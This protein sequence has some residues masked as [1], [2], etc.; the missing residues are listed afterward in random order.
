[1]KSD[2]TGVLH[3]QSA[4]QLYLLNKILQYKSPE[5]SGT[6]ASW[7]HCRRAHKKKEKLN[8]NKI[9]I[10]DFLLSLLPLLSQDISGSQM[11]NLSYLMWVHC[12][13]QLF[14]YTLVMFRAQYWK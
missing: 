2:A 3:F 10:T 5:R 6:K 4:G 7:Q 9:F 14:H 11:T 13:N 8:D 12:Q 1:M